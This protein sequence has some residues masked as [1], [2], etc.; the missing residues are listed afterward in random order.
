MHFE[1][2]DVTIDGNDVS[3]KH[4]MTLKRLGH[5]RRRQRDVVKPA[6]LMEQVADE[7]AVPE[8][9]PDHWTLLPSNGDHLTVHVVTEQPHIELAIDDCRLDRPMDHGDEEYVAVA[10]AQQDLFVTKLSV[11]S[12]GDALKRRR[13][14][15]VDGLI[16]EIVAPV[17]FL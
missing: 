2:L 9:D 12:Y 7:D 14:D 10:A 15:L 6:V 13:F 8:V 17:I 11:T 16:D 3:K 4:W 1:E 5:Q